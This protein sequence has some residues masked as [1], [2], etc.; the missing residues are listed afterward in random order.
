MKNIELV[1]NKQKD[2]NNSKRM[3]LSYRIELLNK[4]KTNILKYEDK[5]YDALKIELAKTPHESYSSEISLILNEI[6]YFVKNLKKISKPKSINNKF[7]FWFSSNNKI[8]N[9][10]YGT[11]LIMS[12]FNYP[13]QLLFVPLI[14]AIASGNRAFVK[15][16]PLSTSSTPVIRSVLADTFSEE[17]VFFVE[18]TKENIDILFDLKFDFVFFT[19]STNM[20]KII[21][22]KLASSLIP[23]VLELG[24]KCPVIIDNNVDLCLTI[25]RLLW[26]KLLNVGQTCIAADYV[27]VNSLIYDD[28]ISELIRQLKSNYNNALCDE[29]FGKII[30]LNN[31]NRLLTMIN[32]QKILFGGKSDIDSLKIEPTII[33]IDN[34]NNILL[35]EEIFGPILPI[36]KYG[37]IDE[38]LNI[39]NL[40][41]DPLAIYVFTQD[42]KFAKTI[43]DKTRSG[44]FVIND[45]LFQITKQ[46]PFGGIKNSGIGNYHFLWSFKCFTYERP[47]VKTSKISHQLRFEP[48]KVSLKKLKSII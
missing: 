27:I 40:N 15:V 3:S 12:P 37:K 7:P 13:F 36:L 10:P 43:F 33:E 47:Y 18:N 38:I 19:G 21:S 30:D 46:L 32:K 45:V 34:T 8:I 2:E 35:K 17:I 16:S 4:L 25:K 11:V 9:E 6:D 28:F 22:S 29:K 42:N 1:L 5:I 26:G 41:P 14:G 24:G 23:M 39:I 44:S 48:H 31:F 20:G